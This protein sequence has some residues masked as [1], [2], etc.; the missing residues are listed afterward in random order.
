MISMQSQPWF[1]TSSGPLEA[2]IIEQYDDSGFDHVMVEVDPYRYRRQIQ[3]FH[4]IVHFERL[5]VAYEYSPDG[6]YMEI[7]LIWNLWR[8]SEV[9]HWSLAT[10]L[11]FKIT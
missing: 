2:G 5:G 7:S 11:I 10:H 9:S 6:G 4:D 3:Q 1:L 8:L